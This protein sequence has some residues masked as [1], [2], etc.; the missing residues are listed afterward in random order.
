MHSLFASLAP[1]PRSPSAP[2]QSPSNLSHVNPQKPLYQAPPKQCNP[3]LALANFLSLKPVV[4]PKKPEK[5]SHVTEIVQKFHT[6]A[7]WTYDRQFLSKNY[8]DLTTYDQN[9]LLSNVGNRKLEYLTKDQ[10]RLI[11]DLNAHRAGDSYLKKD[12]NL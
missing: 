12:L 2:I 6:S 3:L 7:T 4:K 1:Q 9:R 11:Q 10:E 5:I 8:P